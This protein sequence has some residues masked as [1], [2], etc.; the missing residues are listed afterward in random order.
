MG[1]GL[2]WHALLLAQVDRRGN[3]NVSRFGEKRPGPGG[4]INITQGTKR[5]VFSGTL[6]TGG[7][8]E[9]IDGA[10]GIRIVSEGRIRKWVNDVEEVTFSGLR[11]IENGQ[12]VLY[13]TDRAVFVLEEDGPV[14]IEIAEGVDL[15]HD[16]LAHVEFAV[17]VSPALRTMDR[18]LFAS[19]PIG[20]AERFAG[21]VK[22][23]E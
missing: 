14:L 11:A 17:R 19:G 16:V 15:Q 21:E 5:V 10:G 2:H 6:T 1:V 13:V 23:D 22:A 4:F 20:L 18:R 12:Q 7:L 9:R 8:E 3:V